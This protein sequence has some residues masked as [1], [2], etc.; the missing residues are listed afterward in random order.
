MNLED[1]A[2]RLE[3]EKEMVTWR[4]GSKAKSFPIFGDVVGEKPYG[5]LL[6]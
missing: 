4:K 1:L 2:K 5:S 6:C 3:K